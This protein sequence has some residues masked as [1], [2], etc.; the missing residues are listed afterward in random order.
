MAIEKILRRSE[1]MTING[2]GKADSTFD[3]DTRAGRHPPPDGYLGAKRP[4]WWQSTIERHQ[5]AL[6]E[7]PVKKRHIRHQLASAAAS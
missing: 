1:V 5:K 7:S 3:D 4:F 2:Y 6:R